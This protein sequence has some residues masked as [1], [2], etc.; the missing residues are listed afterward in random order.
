MQSAVACA[1]LAPRINGACTSCTIF[2][3]SC[4]QSLAPRIGDII[5]VFIAW[6][7]SQDFLAGSVWESI[8]PATGAIGVQIA[9]TTLGMIT[10]QLASLRNTF[11]QFLFAFQFFDMAFFEAVFLPATNSFNPNLTVDGKR[12][13]G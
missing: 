10:L 12:V 13:A 2:F 5:E 6:C 1:R 8:V 7:N 11:S 9:A 3:V 4:I